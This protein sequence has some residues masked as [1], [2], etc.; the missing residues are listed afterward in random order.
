MTD[1]T[2]QLPED[3]VVPELQR[4]MNDVLEQSQLGSLCRIALDHITAMSDV[5]GGAVVAVRFRT[6]ELVSTCGEPFATDLAS[7]PLVSKALAQP[8]VI[9]RVLEPQYGGEI[10][11]IPLRVH[12]SNVGVVV[13]AH[14]RSRPS[15]RPISTSRTHHVQSR[16]D[17]LVALMCSVLA[18]AMRH[19]AVAQ[20]IEHLAS[21]DPVSG[22]M[23]NRLGMQRL[24][25]EVRRAS[26]S[27]SRV[28]LLIIDLDHFKDVND[29]Y[30]AMVGDQLLSAIACG[31]KEIVRGE[32]VL[33]H[34]SG[35]TFM[36][37]TANASAHDVVRVAERARRQVATTVIAVKTDSGV[38]PV[39]VT[40]SVG[41]VS[42]PDHP[43][44]DGDELFR[45]AS[46]A[47]M[48]A[49]ET[50]RDQHMVAG[51]LNVVAFSARGPQ[52]KG[53]DAG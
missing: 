17:E 34:T 26:R 47:L 3:L 42:F 32:D 22:L 14:N 52:G 31:L 36:V 19:C 11:L 21:L 45:A 15:L 13:L 35:G 7:S 16:Q 41:C 33:A 25:E 30:G 6:L 39:S 49:K 24:N 18:L 27:K 29:N 50:G 48:F 12:G 23:N 9:T 4:F 5:R 20:D 40:A 10:S 46:E 44:H 38:T 28:G 51:R 8:E 2:P 37:V 53:N 1:K 43:A